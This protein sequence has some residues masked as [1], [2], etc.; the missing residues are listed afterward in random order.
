VD[1]LLDQG[2]SIEAM[3]A[4]GRSPLICAAAEG[5]HHVVE[6]FLRRKASPPGKD[7]RENYALRW[8]AFYGHVDVADLLLHK[9]LAINDKNADGLTPLHLAVVD[10]SFQPSS[11][12][13][14]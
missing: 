5:Y 2:A 13:S 11:F 9:K 14:A 1:V 6:L 10:L 7:E 3:G 8:A 4:D 12:F